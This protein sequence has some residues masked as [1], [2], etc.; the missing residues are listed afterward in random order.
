MKNSKEQTVYYGHIDSN[1]WSLYLAVTETGLC[2]VGKGG[3]SEMNQWFEKYRPKARLVEGWDNVS[4]YAA[5]LVEYLN[6]YRKV[7][8]LSVDLSGTKFQEAVWTELQNIPYGETKT[9]TDIS[10]N[11]GKPSSV[12]AVGTAIGANPILIVVPCHRVIRKSGKLAGYRGGIL[13]KEKLIG[14]E[15]M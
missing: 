1:G 12:R 2:F 11:I 15:S 13:M 4:T 14:L 8:D 10:K 6:G 5:E 3:I 7:F 9:Y